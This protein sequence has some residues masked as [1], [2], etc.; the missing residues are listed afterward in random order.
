MKLYKLTS[1]SFHLLFLLFSVLITSLAFAQ[2]EDEEEEDSA[3]FSD[4]AEIEYISIPTFFEDAVL[5]EW[6]DVG[7]TEYSIN[8][9]YIVPEDSDNNIENEVVVGDGSGFVSY[10]WSPGDGVEHFEISISYICDDGSSI[11]YN[12]E[13]ERETETLTVEHIIN[14]VINNDPSVSQHVNQ[15]VNLAA[16]NFTNCNRYHCKTVNSDKF[17]FYSVYGNRTIVEQYNNSNSQLCS[18]MGTAI[19]Q[20]GGASVSSVLDAFR[21]SSSSRHKRISI[22]NYEPNLG[23]ESASN[24]LSN[25]IEVYSFNIYPNPVQKRAEISFEI[26]KISDISI[27]I[28]NS[29]GILVK[30]ILSNINY[31]KGN[32]KQS[33]N[34]ENLSPGIYYIILR[35]G[36]NSN[37]FTR[38]IKY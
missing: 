15:T 25:N 3:S 12:L 11:E 22:G 37:R 9:T 7:E 4:C 13:V 14:P 33:I 8:I 29:N 23:C 34:I 16:P 18:L 1:Y 26:E 32:H 2:I 19:G 27:D 17:V 35:E 21:N 36:N 28:I 5:F 24:R 6:E 20:P 10:E 31:N 30:S 38:I